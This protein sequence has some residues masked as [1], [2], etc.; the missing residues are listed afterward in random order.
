MRASALP[1]FVAD[2][3]KQPA[4]IPDFALQIA[5]SKFD[6]ILTVLNWISVIFGREESVLRHGNSLNGG[7]KR[8][9]SIWDRRRLR[10]AG[11]IA[12]RERAGRIDA[13]VHS[14]MCAGRC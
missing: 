6:M 7:A 11:R 1:A 13:P 10:S 14:G 4:A 9:A 3:G 5:N 8:F 12:E 2:G